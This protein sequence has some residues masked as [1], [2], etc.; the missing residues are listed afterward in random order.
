MAGK[1]WRTRDGKPARII[2]TNVKN[3]QGYTVMVAVESEPG[4]EQTFMLLSDMRAMPSDPVP[5]IMEDTIE[6]GWINVIVGPVYYEKDAIALA[7]PVYPT[8]EIALAK[9]KP[10]TVYHTLPINWSIG[11]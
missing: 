1:K 6:T 8:R 9:R 10:G 4:V 11:R 3:P 2:A 5:F 7:S